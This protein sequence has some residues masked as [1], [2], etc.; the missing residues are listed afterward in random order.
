MRLCIA[1]MDMGARIPKLGALLSSTNVY[2]FLD[3]K[4]MKKKNR[5]YRWLERS[6]TSAARPPT[7][8]SP[9]MFKNFNIFLNLPLQE[10]K[11]EKKKN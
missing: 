5:C 10:K 8:S 4:K 1:M 3:V 11:N 7:L 2:F 9:C 6:A